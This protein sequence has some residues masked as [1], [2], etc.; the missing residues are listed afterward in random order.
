[1][2]YPFYISIAPAILPVR[3]HVLNVKSAQLGFKIFQYFICMA[4][5]YYFQGPTHFKYIIE[6]PL[7]AVWKRHTEGEAAD[8]IG[9]VEGEMQATK[10]KQCRC[11]G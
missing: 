8:L 4:R 6:D 9:D 7:M 1:V 5:I 10:V 3:I 2:P 11:P